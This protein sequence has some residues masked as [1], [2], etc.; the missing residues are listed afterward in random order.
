MCSLDVCMGFITDT[1]KWPGWVGRHLRAVA[2]YFK[3]V[4]PKS[5][6]HTYHT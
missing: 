5:T 2:R 6:Y 3:V 4:W 1:S